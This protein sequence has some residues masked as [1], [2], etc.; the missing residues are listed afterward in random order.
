ME[1]EGK[2]KEKG[3]EREGKEVGKELLSIQEQIPLLSPPFS[4]SWLNK[5][6]R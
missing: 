3:K 1:Q 4:A 5:S 6:T 2:S